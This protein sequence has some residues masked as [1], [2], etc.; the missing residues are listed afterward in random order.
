[1]PKY[2]VLNY[3]LV[4]DL[5]QDKSFQWGGCEVRVFIGRVEGLR[6]IFLEPANNF[7][8]CGVIYGADFM[9]VPMTDAERFGFFAKASLEFILQSGR[10]PDILHCHDWQTAPA[11]RSYWEAR[12][13]P[14]ARERS[15]TR[16]LKPSRAGC[17]QRLFLL[18][19]ILGQS[20][21]ASACP[22]PYSSAMPARA[23][24]CDV[25]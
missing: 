15:R 19:A 12:G 16:A 1:M 9:P 18:S 25:C 23:L 10:K 8:N 4:Q 5:K 24:L 14:R 6:T 2:D 22:P 21:L 7:F 17:S 3:S 13:R 20:L 11:A